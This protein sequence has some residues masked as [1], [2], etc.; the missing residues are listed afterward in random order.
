M[1]EGACVDVHKKYEGLFFAT[2]KKEMDAARTICVDCPVRK[3][4]LDYAMKDFLTH[5][6]WGGSNKFQRAKLRDGTMLRDQ[7][8]A[9]L[10]GQVRF[11][12]VRD[13]S[14]MF[15]HVYLD[16]LGV[17]DGDR[18]ESEDDQ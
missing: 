7:H 12:G 9:W 3:E 4:C 18:T 1:D 2:T 6:I 8:W 10:D 11:Y 16:E 13:Y 14:T 15:Q 17:K 5:G